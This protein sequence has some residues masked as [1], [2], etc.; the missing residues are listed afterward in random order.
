MGLLLPAD[1]AFPLWRFHY[2]VSITSAASKMNDGLPY[3]KGEMNPWG[4]G[5]VV[6]E[7]L[8][9]NGVRK[10]VLRS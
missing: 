9:L 6:K 7:E 3:G 2:G 1:P 4:R 10:W 8:N 5:A